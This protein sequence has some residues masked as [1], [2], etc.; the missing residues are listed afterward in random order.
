MLYFE[1]L[2][3]SLL[4]SFAE[5]LRPGHD[6]YT[7][8]GDTLYFHNDNMQTIM[9]RATLQAVTDLRNIQSEYYAIE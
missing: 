2:E 4:I 9:S 6:K 3:S 7:F 5:I 1:V 8:H